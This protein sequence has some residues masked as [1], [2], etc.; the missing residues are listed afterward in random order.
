[1][2]SADI[3]LEMKTLIEKRS[4]LLNRIERAMSV[5]G[6]VHGMELDGMPKKKPMPVNAINAMEILESLL[7]EK[8]IIEDELR[9]F[10]RKLYPRFMKIPE[11]LSKRIIEKRYW[12]WLTIEEVA[13]LIGYDKRYVIKKLREG[14]AWISKESV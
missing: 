4:R 1:M 2:N 5:Y 9:V 14:E 6:D 13:K 8:S 7:E 10:G 11:G 3:L 12:E